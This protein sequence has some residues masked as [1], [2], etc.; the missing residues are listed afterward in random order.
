MTLVAPTPENNNSD[1][2]LSPKKTVD[3]LAQHYGITISL[4]S[5]YSMISRGDAP[6]VTYFRGRPKFKIPDIDAWV[7]NNTSDRRR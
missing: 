2:L 4:P 1:Q 7:R 6:K 3:Y 5:L